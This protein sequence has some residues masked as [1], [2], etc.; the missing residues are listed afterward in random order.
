[1]ATAVLVDEFDAG[2]S[3]AR[4]IAKSNGMAQNF[5]FIGRGQA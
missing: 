3:K 5:Y 2:H 1:M 4:R